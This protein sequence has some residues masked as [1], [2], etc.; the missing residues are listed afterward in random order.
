MHRLQ[1]IASSLLVLTAIG[2]FAMSQTHAAVAVADIEASLMD[3][4]YEQ[5]RD[6]SSQ[7]LKETAVV[8]QRA[9]ASY[10]LALGQ[11]RLNQY[12]EARKGFQVVMQM[13][14]QGNELYEKSCLGL[15]EGL[16]MSGF[17][18]DAIKT[19]EDLL[20][21]RPQSSAKSLIY[22][23][24]A[25]AHLK[26]M[27]WQKANDWL[28]KIIKEFPDSPEGTL[29]KQLLEEKEYFT[30]QVGSFLEQERAITLIDELKSRGQYA[31]I[32]ETTA[33]DGHTYYRVRV[34]KL[35]ALDDAQRLENALSRLG[36]PTLIY[37]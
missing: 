36:Y 28:N 18:K 21:K 17:Y 26:L 11:L 35:T 16:T 37:P 25:R 12:P 30:V 33:P 14:P 22:L 2:F 5:V 19:G 7:L 24:L 6:L 23:K 29:A 8:D 34:G 1:K 4:N 15:M 10:Y 9:A 13:V 31:Y 32:V 3:K 27:H 20:R